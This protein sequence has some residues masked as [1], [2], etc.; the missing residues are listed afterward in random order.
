MASWNRDY[1]RAR[2]I[3]SEMEQLYA[4]GT[5]SS[6]GGAFVQRSLQQRLLSKQLES[7]LQSLTKS[8][9]ESKDQNQDKRVAELQERYKALNITNQLHPQSTRPSTDNSILGSLIPKISMY[10]KEESI[11]EKLRKQDQEL[12]TLSELVSKTK[13]MSYTIHQEIQEQNLLLDHTSDRMDMANASMNS[14]TKQARAIS[15]K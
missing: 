8:C 5:D 13:E 15:K 12:K 14:V 9:S 6:R 3:L 11:E 7:L 4:L 2:G 10:K 1:D